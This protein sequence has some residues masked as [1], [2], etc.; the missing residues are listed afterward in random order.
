MLYP[1]LLM[2][3]LLWIGLNGRNLC[4]NFKFFHIHIVVL[5]D[6]KNREY[7]RKKWYSS[8]LNALTICI[9]L[10]WHDAKLKQKTLWRR[11]MMNSG[12]ISLEEKNANMGW[13]FVLYYFFIWFEKCLL[14]TKICSS[15]A[16]DR[17]ELRGEM[18]WLAV[19]WSLND[20]SIYSI[21]R[22]LLN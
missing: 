15:S 6:I 1:S 10:I 5:L 8:K 16:S 9:F 7:Y 14:N 18:Q 11:F 12:I 2:R 20:H 3:A 19:S 22:L 17:S 4:L 21:Y 13:W